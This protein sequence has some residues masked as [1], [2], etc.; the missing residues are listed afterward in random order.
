MDIN[1]EQYAEWRAEAETIRASSYISVADQ[2]M[3]DHRDALMHVWRE[4]AR[5]ITNCEPSSE[6]LLWKTVRMIDYAGVNA[7]FVELPDID[8]LLNGTNK[9][10]QRVLPEPER[11]ARTANNT[12]QRILKNIRWGLKTFMVVEGLD[13]MVIPFDLL[14]TTNSRSVYQEMAYGPVID[15]LQRGEHPAGSPICGAWTKPRQVGSTTFWEKLL[16]LLGACKRLRILIH[17]PQEDDAKE[18]LIKVLKDLERLHKKWPEYFPGIRRKSLTRGIIELQNGTLLAIRHGGGSGVQKVGQNWDF[19]ILSEAGKYERNSPGAWSKINTAIIPAVHAG[20]WRAVIH[21]GTNDELAYELQRIAKLAQLPHSPYTFFFFNWTII[22]DYVGPPIGSGRIEKSS[23][24]R[25]H[26]YEMRDGERTAVS[27]LHYCIS[28]HGLTAEQIGFRRTMIDKLG[29]LELFHQEYP[30]TYD[31]SCVAVSSKFFGQD[32]LSKTYPDPARKIDFRG[33]AY[34]EDKATR[35]ADLIYSVTDSADGRW[36]I[37]HE[38]GEC[39]D[40]SKGRPANI[41]AGDFSDGIPGGDYTCL[42]LW[43]V[44]CGEQLAGS[45]FR[46]G[47]RNEIEIASEIAYATHHYQ[48]KRTTVIGEMNNVGKA[49]RS[50]WIDYRHTLN[51][52]RKLSRDSFDVESDSMWFATGYRNR[53][54]ALLALRTMVSTGRFTINDERWGIQSQDF[55]KHDNGKY[56]HAEAVSAVTGE[57]AHD[58]YIIMSALACVAM[59]GHPKYVGT[60]AKSAEE[61]IRAPAEEDT[62]L[63]G[64]TYGDMLSGIARDLF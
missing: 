30:L 13:R 48:R 1:L 46:G 45:M 28:T 33:N 55:I 56:A 52:F 19:V 2:T 59:R 44:Y 42:G 58:D 37:W 31:E 51:Y 24:G 20:P 64:L 38:P 43:C 26:D 36:W 10:R 6:H 50:R 29:S 35:I 11:E 63:D 14:D 9:D 34:I 4:I 41:H 23:S 21:E 27:E 54:E 7:E 3:L 15:K 17:F 8:D 39:C 61:V 16:A 25:Y 57:R 60:V 53:A 62:C 22:K 32:I 49:V 40:A 12:V 18:H 5:K 47:K